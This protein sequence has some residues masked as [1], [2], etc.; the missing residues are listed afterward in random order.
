MVARITADPTQSI[1]GWR[2]KPSGEPLRM[3]TLPPCMFAKLTH[4]PPPIHGNG[5]TRHVVVQGKHDGDS[6]NVLH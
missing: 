5:L 6:G 3:P 4:I 1:A 2:L